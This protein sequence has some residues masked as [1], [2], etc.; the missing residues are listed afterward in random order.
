MADRLRK[1]A[2]APDCEYGVEVEFRIMGSPYRLQ[3]NH[4]RY[5]AQKIGF[6]EQRTTPDMPRLSF[7]PLAE[8]DGIVT[9]IIIDLLDACGVFLGPLGAHQQDTPNFH[10]ELEP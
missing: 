5:H 2:G 8:I 7:G 6:L 3:I 10:I 4:W 1:E 9:Q